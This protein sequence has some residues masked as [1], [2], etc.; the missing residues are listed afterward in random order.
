MPPRGEVR[1]WIPDDLGKRRVVCFSLD[2]IK[3]DIYD[4]GTVSSSPHIAAAVAASG[5]PPA[6][7]LLSTVAEF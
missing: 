3:L 7:S 4:Y 5:Y 1:R 2:P 6:A